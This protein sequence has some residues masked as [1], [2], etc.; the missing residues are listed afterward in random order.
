[1]TTSYGCVSSEGPAYWILHGQ[2]HHTP[3]EGVVTRLLW[4][5]LGRPFGWRGVGL[6]WTGEGGPPLQW[7]RRQEHAVTRLSEALPGGIFA[8]N[9]SSQDPLMAN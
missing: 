1:M 3:G 4:L 7:P 2:M 5:V 6:S 8:K 9:L